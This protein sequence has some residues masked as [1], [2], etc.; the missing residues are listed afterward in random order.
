MSK[1]ERMYNINTKEKGIK[2]LTLIR[3]IGITF[4]DSGAR[5]KHRSVYLCSGCNKEIELFTHVASKQISCRRCSPRFRDNYHGMKDTRQW[6]IWT[7]VIA[8]CTRPYN[9]NYEFYKNKKPPEKWENFIGFWDDMKEGW[10][11]GATLDR[12]DNE[13]PYSKENC[14]WTTPQVQAQNKKLIMSTNTSGYRG[15]CVQDGRW[16]VKVNGRYL[17]LC[18]TAIEGAKMYD[19]YVID[20]G[21]ENPL[22]FGGVL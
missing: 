10:F 4:T 2:M 18:A 9:K 1:A 19:K 15:V 20:N 13:K 16:R 11:D 6:S 17:G 12:I 21:L 22:N 3:E 7:G 5:R 14:R 8:R